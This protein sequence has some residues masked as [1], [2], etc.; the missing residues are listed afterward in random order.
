MLGGYDKD[1]II[2]AHASSNLDDDTNPGA[3]YG[4]GWPQPIK[5]K[6]ASKSS[7]STESGL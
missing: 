5:M 3:T 2:L 6:L 7:A 4:N 1:M